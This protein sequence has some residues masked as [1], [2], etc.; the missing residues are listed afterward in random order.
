MHTYNQFMHVDSFIVGI[1]NSMVELQ[2]PIMR[3]HYS[4]RISELYNQ[5]GS[6]AM[7]LCSLENEL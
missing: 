6:S 3:K 4:C 7:Y 2:E 5:F 1:R